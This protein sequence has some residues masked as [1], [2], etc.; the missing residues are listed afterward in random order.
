[1]TCKRD[2]SLIVL[3]LL[4]LSFLTVGPSAAIKDAGDNPI[5]LGPIPGPRHSYPKMESMLTQTLED[6]M[7]EGKGSDGVRAV[8]ELDSD[9][10]IRIAGLKPKVLKIEFSR[11]NLVQVLATPGMI[12]RLSSLGYVN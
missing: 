2:L 4:T 11:G 6:L 3:V 10:A 1:M 7:R 12:F 5:D 8:L 9:A